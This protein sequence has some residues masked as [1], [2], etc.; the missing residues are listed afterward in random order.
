MDEKNLHKD[1]RE[2]VRS[3]FREEGLEHFSDVQVLEFLLFYAIPRKDTNEIAHR[4]LAHFGSL[5]QVLEAPID[6]LQKVEGVGESAAILVALTTA[7]ERYHAIHAAKKVK[8]LRTTEQCAAYVAP[9]FRSLRDEAVYLLCMDAK[10]KPLCCKELSRGSVNS[11]TVSARKVV[12]IA[13][14][15]NATTV[16]LAHNHPAGVAIPSGD[17]VV[18]TRRIGAALDAVGIVL[19]DHLVM[20]DDDYVSMVHSGYYKPEDCRIEF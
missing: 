4:L 13:I 8:V 15:A 18:S 10:G 2:R 19:A 16:I 17:D 7:M 11:A 6:E 20:A 9:Y 1:H 3:R 12:E 5:P 14:S